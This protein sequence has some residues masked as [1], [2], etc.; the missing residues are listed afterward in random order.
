MNAQNDIFDQPASAAESLID[1]LHRSDA[2]FVKKLSVNDR[3]WAS[4]S[5][6][7][8]AG[9]Y[10][11]AR[12]R[13]GGFFPALSVRPKTKPGSQPVLEAYFETRWPQLGVTRQSHLVN[14]TSKGQETHLT[15]LPKQAFADLSPASW[16]IMAPAE[17]GGLDSFT[18]LTID[19]ISEE[20]D[21]L[22]E[23]LQLGADFVSGVVRPAAVMATERDRILEFAEQLAVAWLAGN[24]LQF[25][26]QF[27]TM[28]RT[29]ELAR[30]ARESFLEKA[31]L[32]SLDPFNLANPGDALFQI[33]RVIEWEM[34][35]D[36][37]RRERAV[38]LVR[39]VLGE[40][41]TA[42]DA[43]GFIRRLVD[44]ASEIDDLMMSVSQQ[45]KSRAGYSFEHHI[46]AMLSA[47]AI[48]FEKQ[49]VIE[50][51]KRPDFV[52]P[53]LV[54]LNG[55]REGPGRGLILSAKTTLRE[56]WKQVQREKGD[57]DLYLATVDDNVASNAI[58]DMASMGIYLVVP[59]KLNVSKI[60]EYGRHA[61][62]LDFGTFF[63]DEL[64]SNRLLHWLPDLDRKLI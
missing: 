12:D 34:F 61:N 45:R 62:V 13:D 43:K 32:A 11:F 27:A 51:K 63:R 35:Q 23:A 47:G 49:V 8:Q 42:M 17:K 26:A 36:F 56:R 53:S 57:K 2:V 59:E 41:P 55:V 24:L 28:P 20:A 31:R 1:L 9:I 4:D 29:D 46:G 16:I 15:G 37:Q 38:K 30:Q 58:E 40:A 52:L 14:Y 44:A 64:K 19:S 50:A 60:T 48:P 10:V 3:S 25:A 21:L 6:K 18:C 7:H 22:V 54:H 39:L 5:G 33:S